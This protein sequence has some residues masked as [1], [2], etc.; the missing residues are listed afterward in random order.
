M[1]VNVGIAAAYET[2]MVRYFAF[3]G[4]LRLGDNNI[5]TGGKQKRYNKRRIYR[6]DYLQ[7]LPT[8]TLGPPFE[9]MFRF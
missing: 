8:L 1:G 6:K 4:A 7:S 9:D 5:S 2:F 3:F